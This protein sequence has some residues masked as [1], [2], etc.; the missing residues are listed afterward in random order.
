V[1]Y[2]K[3]SGIAAIL[4][5]LRLF[6]VNGGRINVVVG[7]SQR[8]TSSQALEVLLSEVDNCYVFF[9]ENS[10]TSF[11]PKVYIFENEKKGLVFLG[12][13]NLTA[14]GMYT[15]HELDVKLDFD[16]SIESS[17]KDYNQFHDLYSRYLTLGESFCK[18]LNAELLNELI[19]NK[20]VSD[21]IGDIERE[22]AKGN[23]RRRIFGSRNIPKAGQSISK[24]TP[25]PAPTPSINYGFWKKLSKFDVSSTSAPGQIIIPIRYLYMFPP[26]SGLIQQPSGAQQQEVVFDISLEVVGKT[27]LIEGVRAI[28][29]VPAPTHARHNIELRFTFHN[30]IIFS[31]LGKDDILEFRRSVNSK[32]WFVIKVIPK[33]GPEY[34]KYRNGKFGSL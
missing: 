30:R 33:S 12:S 23:D 29:Y 26:M 34:Y 19:E 17:R 28:R 16:L 14:G 10:F 15:N 22:Q 2:A 7:L 9:E 27:E 6:R 18:K 11:H 8:L 31:K 20:Y 32:S 1:A 21:E 4:P 25:Q 3:K 13:S 24:V 5:F